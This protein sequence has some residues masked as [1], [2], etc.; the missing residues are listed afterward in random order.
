[1]FNIAKLLNLLT[2]SAKKQAAAVDMQ[3]IVQKAI[4]NEQQKILETYRR[5]P[6][7]YAIVE[8]LHTSRDDPV[9][10]FT[11]DVY[12]TDEQGLDE[13]IGCLHVYENAELRPYPEPRSLASDAYNVKKAA[14]ATTTDQSSK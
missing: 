14:A 9:E 12:Q 2:S 13:P 11:V 3:V 4:A 7:G 6:T 10:H 8:C 5:R 1:M